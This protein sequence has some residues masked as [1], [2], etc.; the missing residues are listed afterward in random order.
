MAST[1]VVDVVVVDHDLDADLGDEVDL[2]L[3]AA[4]DLGVAL[5]SAVALRLG[6]RSCQWTPASSTAVRTSVDA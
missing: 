5:L 1:T 4:V 2:V 6:E 3:G